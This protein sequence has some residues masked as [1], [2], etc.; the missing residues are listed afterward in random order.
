MKIITCISLLV[1]ATL[2]A[3]AQGETQQFHLSLS[4]PVA[5][6][7][8]IIIH[9]P[10]GT[11]HSG[12]YRQSTAFF[13][14]SRVN[15]DGL[16]GSYVV[17][18]DKSTVYILNIFSQY[19]PGTWVKGSLRGDTLYVP[20]P[21]HVD[22]YSDGSGTMELYLQNMKYDERQQNYVVDSVHTDAR[23]VLSG[24]T[25][26]QVSPQLLG[27]TS[28]SGGYLG[29]G[30][31][32]ILMFV[33]R[34]SINTMPVGLKTT[35]YTL[36]Y[37]DEYGDRQQRLVRM[38]FNGSDVWLGNLS[39]LYPSRWIKGM[40]KNGRITFDNSQY[41]G[42]TDRHHVYFVTG[43][44]VP[45][46]DPETGETGET[47]ELARNIRFDSDGDDYA[48]DNVMFTNWGKR[49]VNFR[50]CFAQPRLSKFVETEQTPQNPT[51]Q[52]FQT[53]DASL[54]YGSVSFTI[55]STAVSGQ[56]LNPD[57]IFY[58]VYTDERLLTFKASRYGLDHD[59]TDIPLNFADSHTFAVSA[60][61]PSVHIVYF[62]ERVGT[63]YRHL[64]IRA[65]YH[66]AGKVHMSDIVYNDGDIVSGIKEITGGTSKVRYYNLS[67]QQVEQPMHGIYVVKSQT[68]DGEP[69]QSKVL[70]K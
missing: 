15:A 11:L 45:A 5:G 57:S 33:N 7:T 21:Q 53:Y 54:K 37:K 8:D 47:Y 27:M 29:Y 65:I 70:I 10:T 62:K 18:P 51:I 26:R 19:Q 12:L 40:L 2:P 48:A 46:T 32:D 68:A 23:F 52:A 67:G 39:A 41:L 30:D 9:T 55:P 36:S 24:D 3:Q 13:A 44:T 50:E 31:V 49:D 34:D 43:I 16:A 4:S 14:G 56:M 20:T 28:A 1:L 6:S 58:N 35:R 42:F 63:Y 64:G 17:S 25:L 66:G 69:V 22:S 60:D 59:M 61:D 38:G